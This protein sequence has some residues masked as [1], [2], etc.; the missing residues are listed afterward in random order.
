MSGS[1]RE[2]HFG[3]LIITIPAYIHVILYYFSKPVWL[4]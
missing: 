1:D 3:A 2:V 4:T